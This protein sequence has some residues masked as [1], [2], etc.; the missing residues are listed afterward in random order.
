[1]SE[2]KPVIRW[3]IHS[4]FPEAVVHLGHGKRP[5]GG[6][7]HEHRN[8]DC[9]AN[10]VCRVLSDGFGTG[11]EANAR[12]IAAAPDL[13]AALRQAQ[14]ALAMMVAPDAIRQTT[15]LTAYAVAVE[16]EAKARSAITKAT[17]PQ[18]HEVEA[19]RHWE[20]TKDAF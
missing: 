4:R 5:Y 14:S 7:V 20:A 13:I 11:R 8:R 9:Y 18:P 6:S 17:E 3:E 19:D 12:L 10:V 2:S 15:I 1:V 16:A